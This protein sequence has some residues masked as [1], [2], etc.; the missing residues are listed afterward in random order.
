L[1]EEFQCF[2]FFSKTFAYNTLNLITCAPGKKLQ[3]VEIPIGKTGETIQIEYKKPKC[4][5][6]CISDVKMLR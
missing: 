1:P 3:A 4:H 6:V 2:F 5:Q